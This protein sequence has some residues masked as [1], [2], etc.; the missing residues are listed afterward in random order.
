MMTILAGCVSCCRDEGTMSVG[1]LNFFSLSTI[2]HEPHIIVSSII[3]NG[4]LTTQKYI[5]LVFSFV[6]IC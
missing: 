6:F 1:F 4:Q 2:Q 3:S 5:S